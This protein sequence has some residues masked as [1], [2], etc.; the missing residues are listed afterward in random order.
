MPL[1]FNISILWV[2]KKVLAF[3][4]PNTTH[5]MD[6]IKLDPLPQGWT[7]SFRFIEMMDDCPE[8]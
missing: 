6:K 5:E 8:M 7:S 2:F 3:Y 4:H 1:S